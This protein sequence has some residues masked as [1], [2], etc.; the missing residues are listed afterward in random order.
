[1]EFQSFKGLL[2]SDDD[3]FVTPF[4]TKK[5]NLFFISSGFDTVEE[6]RRESEYFEALTGLVALRGPMLQADV[7]EW[8]EK[9]VQFNIAHGGER[10]VG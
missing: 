4:L 9:L 7:A 6:A 10:S 3:Y 2:D 1:M 5:D 8:V